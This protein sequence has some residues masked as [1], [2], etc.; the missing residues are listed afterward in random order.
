MTPIRPSVEAQLPILGSEDWIA[1][2]DAV[3][4][5]AKCSI[6]QVSTRRWMVAHPDDSRMDLLIAQ[7]DS[8][9]MGNREVEQPLVIRWLS[10]LDGRLYVLVEY[11]SLV[12][13]LPSALIDGPEGE[14]LRLYGEQNP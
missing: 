7:I 5:E 10:R 4:A 3:L 11:F 13:Q 14:S 12:R 2:S 6:A 1:W 8:G 9:Q